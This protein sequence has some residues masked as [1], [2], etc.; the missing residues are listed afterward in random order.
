MLTIL[1][2]SDSPRGRFCDGLSRRN[3]LT[4]GGMALGGL[5]LPGLLKAEAAAGVGRSHKAIINVFLAGGPPHLDMW[6]LKPEAPREIRGEFQPIKTNVPGIDICEL[7]PEMAKMMDKFAIIRSLVQARDA[8]YTFQCLTGYHDQNQPAGGRPSMGAWVS[9]LQGA[10]DP[11]V[12]PHMALMYE[13]DH[14]P[15]GYPGEGGF[16]G[17]AHAPFNLVGG[18]QSMQQQDG[19][20]GKPAGAANMVL[21]GITVERLSDRRRL[22]SALD[23]FRRDADASG[24]MEGLDEFTQQAFGIL[25]S[26]KL[27][28]AMDLSK[29]DPK[30][31]ERYG[32]GDPEFRADGAPKMTEN[33][34]IARRLVEAGARVVSL[35]F[36]RWDWHGGNFDRGRQDFPMLDKAVSALVSDLHERGLDKD[37]SV[38]V[39][40]EFGRTPKI[41]KDAGRDHWPQVNCAL[42]AGGGM[43]MGQVIG[44]TNRLGEHATERPVTFQ[45]VFATLYTNLG[46]DVGTVR[47]FDLRGRPQYL[48]EPGTRPISELI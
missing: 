21:Q 32:K 28:E 30:T 4:I 6:D 29:E 44:A 5:S 45:E 8:H 1:G 14:R 19:K 47:E 20:N 22:L 34:C 24:K 18:R 39:W 43:R 38:V 36:S 11:A 17:V 16:L 15:W 3:F 37:V 10:A 40:G 42:L 23:N 31:V 25:T 7:F 27:A 26:S 9:K 46:L 13:T 33:F 48:V 12:P 2:R 41:N 35:N